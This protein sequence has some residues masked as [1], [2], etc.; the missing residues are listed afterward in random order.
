[1]KTMTYTVLE[2]NSVLT[3]LS[4]VLEVTN[5]VCGCNSYA[6]DLIKDAVEVV[7]GGVAGVGFPAVPVTPAGDASE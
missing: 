7:E 3:N 5:D 6:S 4:E 1:M 2:M